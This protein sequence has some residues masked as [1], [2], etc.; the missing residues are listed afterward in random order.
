MDLQTMSMAPDLP[1][2]KAMIDIVREATDWFEQRH[3][4]AIKVR[5]VIRIVDGKRYVDF[6]FQLKT[7]GLLPTPVERDTFAAFIAGYR[8]AINLALAYAETPPSPPTDRRLI[9]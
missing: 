6:A 3:G 2:M 5:S 1:P 8:N 4:R 9:N 7:A